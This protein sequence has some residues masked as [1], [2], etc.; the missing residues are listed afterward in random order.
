MKSQTKMTLSRGRLR[1]L[2]LG[3]VLFMLLAQV[4]PVRAETRTVIIDSVVPNP[5]VVGQSVTV[6]VS[7]D[8]N[9]GDVTVT[10]G[11]AVC[12]I[13]TYD[14]TTNKT[15]NLILLSAGGKSLTAR[16]NNGADSGVSGAAL[17][18]VNK[19]DTSTSQTVTP[20]AVVVGQ[21]VL[22]GFDVSASSPGSGSPDGTVNVSDG[23]GHSCSDQ[24]PGGACSLSF[25]AVGDY[26][27]TSTYTGSA[28]FNGSTSSGAVLSV[29]QGK[30]ITSLSLTGGGTIGAAVTANV[31]VAAIAP[32]QGTPGGGVT[33]SA[34]PD[35]TSCLVTL[36]GGAGSCQLIFNTAGQRTLT[37]AYAG[38]ASFA[39]SSA[40]RTYQVG[41]NSGLTVNLSAPTGT[42][43][44][45][46][47]LS[48]SA[49]VSNGSAS[50]PTGFVAFTETG[51]D[52]LMC[53]APL[54][55][56]TAACTYAFP[57]SGG[58]VVRADYGGDDNNQ[59][60][61]SSTRSLTITQSNANDPK[62]N[63][64]QLQTGVNTISIN[65]LTTL[66]F[67]VDASDPDSGQSVTLEVT[68]ELAGQYNAADK[69]FEWTPSEAQDRAT[70]YTVTFTAKDNGT[71]QRTQTRTLSITVNE[72]NTVPQITML[73]RSG[74][75][76]SLILFNLAGVDP[77]NN[78][79]LSYAWLDTEKPLGAQFNPAS[80]SFNW[81]PTELQDG[82]Y[83]FMFRVTDH[84]G[85]YADV[86]VVVV[87]NEV[88]QAPLLAAIP[89]QATDPYTPLSF[90]VTASDPDG[91]GRVFQYS[92]VGDV[93]SGAAI[94]AASGVFSWKPQTDQIGAYTLTVKAVDPERSTL[95][96]TV[97]VKIQVSYMADSF[98]S[99]PRTTWTTYPKESWAKYAWS[100]GVFSLTSKKRA[101][102]TRAIAPPVNLGSRYYIESEMASTGPAE[103]GFGMMFDVK[104]VSR[105]KQIFYWI[106]VSANKGWI[107][108]KYDGRRW[109]NIPGGLADLLPEGVQGQARYRLRVERTEDL[110]TIKMKGCSADGITCSDWA[111]LVG[112]TGVSAFNLPRKAFGSQ[113]GIFVWGPKKVSS[114]LPAVA[115]FYRFLAGPLP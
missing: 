108:Q 65:E 82:L 79:T 97:T 51:G 101:Y 107:L 43:N 37:A 19:A 85:A 49:T 113:A 102:N 63:F 115:S 68:G 20:S 31:T 74:D 16:Y 11:T 7:V 83:P 47:V 90:T 4:G 81:T 3:L 36:S 78:E 39:A 27:L 100:A 94:H 8:Q 26:T 41:K 29:A 17:L 32:A 48:F 86:P 21:T 60:A 99:D 46:E 92:L 53:A 76:G 84:T 5:S 106:W 67:F 6:A 105:T 112:K 24:A 9:G 59:E 73:K 87:V 12:V 91:K 40:A 2:S 30:T 45:G 35:G 77:D 109:S 14:S 89:D 70:P 98:T 54:V 44:V 66:V 61:S 104:Q 52:D 22:V 58:K 10:D 18:T 38:E 33:V 96:S 64:M 114:K 93:P 111:T 34:A 55:N 80:G 1:L 103:A 88:F 110:V 56:G 23:G 42:R 71:P 25:G 75:E 95:S 72:V 13:T 50:K 57:S 69:K 62:L 28:N 15:C